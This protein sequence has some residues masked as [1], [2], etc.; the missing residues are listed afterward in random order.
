M[1]EF[2][3]NLEIQLDNYLVSSGINK[4]YK[5]VLLKH[6]KNIMDINEVNNNLI[7]HSFI[8]STLN[9][10]CLMHFNKG[11]LFNT[12][13]YIINHCDDINTL[14][15]QEPFL[16][17]NEFMIPYYF[18]DPGSSVVK[19]TSNINHNIY[20]SADKLGIF[21]I[22]K[23]QFNKVSMPNHIWSYSN[24]DPLFTNLVKSKS[25]P[26]KNIV[27]SNINVTDTYPEY[28][29]MNHHITDNIVTLEDQLHYNNFNI[30]QDNWFTYK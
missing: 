30:N 29:I 11:I 24:I 16:M 20:S 15:F 28:H 18:N 21:C 7:P 1:E 6:D 25:I 23:Q 3:Y 27:D 22:S 4:S 13:S 5:I 10:K 19:L 8:K 12:A 9:E 26:I 2:I 17:P 14:L